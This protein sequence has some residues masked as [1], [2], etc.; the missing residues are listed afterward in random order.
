[1]SLTKLG[2]SLKTCKSTITYYHTHVLFCFQIIHMVDYQVMQSHVCCFVV[3]VHV[4]T[5][6]VLDSLLV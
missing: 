5:Y 4:C 1:M 6:T 2:D 3:H